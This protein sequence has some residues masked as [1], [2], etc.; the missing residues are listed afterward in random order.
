MNGLS[1]RPRVKK[2]SENQR[3]QPQGGEKHQQLPCGAEMKDFSSRA[4]M[5]NLLCLWHPF[6]KVEMAEDKRLKMNIQVLVRRKNIVVGKPDQ[7][8]EVLATALA[9]E[10]KS[11]LRNEMT[12]MLVVMAMHAQTRRINET[13]GHSMVLGAIVELHVPTHGDE[14]HH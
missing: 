11:V 4:I 2:N 8:V 14:K 9:V 5:E 7:A 6:L 13:A 10:L 3:I 1:W 12:I